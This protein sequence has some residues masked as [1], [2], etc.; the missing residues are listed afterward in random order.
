MPSYLTGQTSRIRKPAPTLR[1]HSSSPFAAAPRTKA[2]QRTKSLADAYNDEVDNRTEC[3]E[4]TGKVVPVVQVESAK[5]LMTAIHHVKT[6]MFCELP[7]RAGMNST[8]IAEVLNFHKSLPPVVSLAHVHSVISASS[9]TERQISELLASGELRKLKLIGRGNDISGLGELLI[10]THD[11]KTLLQ[12]A[13]VSQQ[14]LKSFLEVLQQHPR[15]TTISSSLL[16]NSHVTILTRAGFLVSSS[17]GKQRGSTSNELSV[18]AIPTISRANS[19]TTAAVGGEA[20]FENLGG[21]GAAKRQNSGSRVGNV[22]LALSVP[23]IGVYARLLD[24]GRKHLLGLLGKSKY[25][26]VPLYLLRERWDGAVDN[27]GSVSTAKRTRGEFSEVMPAKTK[28]WAKISGLNFNWALEECHGAGL[29]DLFETR[30]VGLGVRA[31][32]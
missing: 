15:A 13:G 7:A 32:D 23:N 10:L 28:K 2:F 22:E 11:L 18:V 20:A 5:D 21:V 17:P 12:S 8:H 29:I 1:R 24:A 14:V 16:P 6:T 4:A 19:G 26:E 30:S 25:K 3:L 31:L 27:E 9:K